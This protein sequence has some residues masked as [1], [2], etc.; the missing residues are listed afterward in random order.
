[1]Q[2]DAVIYSLY[3]VLDVGSVTGATL[4]QEREKLAFIQAYLFHKVL[5]LSGGSSLLLL[6]QFSK[7]TSIAQTLSPAC[8]S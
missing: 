3:T 2:L 5:P 6:L 1:M 8:L 7:I 4:T